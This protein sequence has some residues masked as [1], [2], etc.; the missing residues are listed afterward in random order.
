MAADTAEHKRVDD[1]LLRKIAV[2]VTATIIIQAGGWIYMM[3]TIV[4]QV[5][6]NTDTISL[7]QTLVAKQN[8]ETAKPFTRVETLVETLITS[9]NRLATQVD[10]VAIEQ[11]RRTSIVDRADRFMDSHK[12]DKE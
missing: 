1:S 6:N 7:I 9:F 3:G 2:T 11:Q 12:T 4:N 8:D 5:E 10:R